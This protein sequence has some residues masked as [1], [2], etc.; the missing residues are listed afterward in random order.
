[1]GVVYTRNHP[2]HGCGLL[3]RRAETSTEE[4]LPAEEIGYEIAAAVVYERRGQWFRIADQ[5]R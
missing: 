4:E 1:M 3:F 2:E 5:A